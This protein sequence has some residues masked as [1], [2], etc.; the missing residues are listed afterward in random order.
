MK[1]SQSKISNFFHENR[2]R[3][4]FNSPKIF[5]KND[6]LSPTSSQLSNRD[7]LSSSCSLNQNTNNKPD[8]PVNDILKTRDDSPV[9]LN[10]VEFSKIH[11]YKFNP[12]IYN[13]YK[14]FEYSKEK[15]AAFYHT[16]RNFGSSTLKHQH[17]S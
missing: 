3:E 10:L 7:D 2:A 5:K 12:D 15:S 9:Q 16:N 6:S 4:L 13:I 17:R 8:S 1:R 14:W 11:V